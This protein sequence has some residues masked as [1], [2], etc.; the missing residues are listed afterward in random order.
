MMRALLFGFMLLLATPL[1]ADVEC[2]A[3]EQALIGSWA[4]SGD[5]AFFEEMRFSV[6]GQDHI[7]D[8]WLH[9]RPELFGASWRVEHCDLVVQPAR[10]EFK[11]FQFSAQVRGDTLTL[12]PTDDGEDATSATYH[13]IAD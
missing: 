7:F 2:S 13:R 10:G 4:R 1:R 6:D 11:A 12:R 9:Q 5:S 8:S 3:L